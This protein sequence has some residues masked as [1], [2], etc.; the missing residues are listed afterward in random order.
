MLKKFKQTQVDFVNMN[1]IFYKSL[2]YSFYDVYYENF[3][4]NSKIITS[5]EKKFRTK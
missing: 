3:N 2:I 4:Y 1:Q 5:T